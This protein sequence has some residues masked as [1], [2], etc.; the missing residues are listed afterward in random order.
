MKQ[1]EMKWKPNVPN[2]SMQTDIFEANS[3]EEATKIVEAKAKALG[4]T[5]IGW[6]GKREIR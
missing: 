2:F 3:I 5:S 6:F 1:F 4:A